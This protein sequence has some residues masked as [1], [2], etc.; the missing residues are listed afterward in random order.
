MRI[1]LPSI[2]E[3]AHK[4]F[5]FL[6]PRPEKHK[7]AKFHAFGVIFVETVSEIQQ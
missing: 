5:F 3:F 6:N 2:K 4:K 1:K 7:E